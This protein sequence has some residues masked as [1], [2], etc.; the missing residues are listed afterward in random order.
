MSP[1]GLPATAPP[2]TRTWPTP[3]GVVIIVLLV[4]AVGVVAVVVSLA[5]S[6][7]PKAVTDAL[8]GAKKD[9]VGS[10]SAADGSIDLDIDAT[11]EI[12]YDES[13]G[14]RA[15]RGLHD[16]YEADDLSI[17]AFEGDDIVIDSSLR[18]KVTSPPHVVGDHFEMTANGVL[19]ARPGPR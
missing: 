6:R 15:K 11:G 7:S 5:L 14:F 18:I 3:I 16:N 13:S 9:Y 2:P 17:A 10:W 12:S 19:L 8:H 4:V 1:D